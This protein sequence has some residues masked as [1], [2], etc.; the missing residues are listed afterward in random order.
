[1]LGISIFCYKRRELKQGVQTTIAL[2]SWTH[3]VQ[4]WNIWAPIC[5]FYVPVH[6][7]TAIFS[8]SFLILPLNYAAAFWVGSLTVYYLAT[9]VGEPEHTGAP[10]TQ[11]TIACDI[12][13]LTLC[14]AVHQCSPRRRV[15]TQPCRFCTAAAA[16][17]PAVLSLLNAGA[18]L[19][20]PGNNTAAASE[21]T[22]MLHCRSWLQ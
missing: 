1:M 22:C 13:M 3:L 5:M 8:F 4:T 18:A 9:T 20:G 6:M 17:S 11:S 21:P 7:F 14:L 10:E 19:E 2:A 15:R 16:G 12:N